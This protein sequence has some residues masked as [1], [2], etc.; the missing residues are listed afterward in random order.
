[1]KLKKIFSVVSLLLISNHPGEW[2]L[3]ARQASIAR[4]YTRLNALGFEMEA[5][6][7]SWVQVGKRQTKANRVVPA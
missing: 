7:G 3:A 4:F 6:P 1:M 2:I 5:T